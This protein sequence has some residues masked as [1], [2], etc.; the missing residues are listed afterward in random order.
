MQ[1]ATRMNPSWK[2]TKDNIAKADSDSSEN[3][4]GFK[5]IELEKKTKKN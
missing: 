3:Q 5:Q 2:V 4:K 1:L